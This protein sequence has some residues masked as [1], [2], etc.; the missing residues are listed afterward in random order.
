[1]KTHIL[2]P[3]A[4]TPES[5]SVLKHLPRLARRG[6]TV[7]LLR[8]EM[9]AALEQYT[10]LSDAALEHARRYLEGVRERL[11]DLDARVRIVARIGAPTETILDV[12]HQVGATLILLSSRGRPA[13]ARF[14]FGSVAGAVVKRSPLPVLVIPAHAEVQALHIS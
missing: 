5:E 3:L 12:A 2:V 1:M 13:L 6:S 9:P 10:D 7:T 8:A 14:L 11:S 4:G